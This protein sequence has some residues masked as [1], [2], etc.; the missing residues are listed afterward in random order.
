MSNQP[1]TV[2][3][4]KQQRLTDL[5]QRIAAAREAGKPKPRDERKKYA[6]MSMAWRITIEL[7][8]SIA[9]GAAMGWGLDSLF[10]SL[11]AFLVVFTLLGF[12]AGV[13]SMMRTV[14]QDQ[15]RTA[16]QAA[17]DE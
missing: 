7:A 3:G 11:P 6:A 2:P 5:E 17:Q 13:R 12:A 14:E 16:A 10:G 9:V 15:R 8:V 4:D 1:G